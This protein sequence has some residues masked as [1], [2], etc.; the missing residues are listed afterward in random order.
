MNQAQYVRWFRNSAPYINAHRGRVFVIHLPGELVRESEFQ[1]TIHD[2]ALLN[3]IGVRLVLVHGARPQIDEELSARNVDAPFVGMRRIT[4]AT[5]LEVV[6]HAAAGVR[7]RIESA[8]SM[9]LPNSPMDGARIRAAS[10]NYVVAK[11]IGVRDGV[12][13]QHTGEVRRVDSDAI[14][15]RLNEGAV[16]LVSPIGYSP[17]GEVFNLASEELAGAV[18]ASLAADKLILLGDDTGTLSKD[19]ALLRELPLADA[20]ALLKTL[21]DA[22]N[23]KGHGD[24]LRLGAA[25][26][27]C[28]NGVQRVHLLDRALDGALLLELFT[29]DGAGSMINADAYDE[30]RRAAAEDVGGIISLISPLEESGVLVKRSRE[31]LEAEIEHF[32]VM[33]RDGTAIGCAACYP[34]ANG[35]DA[36]LA[37]LAVHPEY[38]ENGRGDTLLSTAEAEARALG[39]KRLFVLTTQTAHW[40]QERGFV[41][42][43]A[44]DLPSDRQ[45]LYNYRR[46]S[47]VLVKT[48]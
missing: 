40:F 42:G 12:D 1:E 28:Q 7:V 9:G 21:Q 36:E 6:I 35:S 32:M 11:P 33:E 38:R 44:D 39:A 4:D 18:A 15:A 17:S 5:S 41:V 25:I 48:L 37:C 26:H 46:N 19:G 2:I 20:E 10:G 27:A 8:L 45:S 29:R 31:K 14:F 34:F 24:T 13:H 3:S 22:P 16:V 30:T 23:D 47:K 43:E